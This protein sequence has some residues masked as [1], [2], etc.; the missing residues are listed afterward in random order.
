MFT[1]SC[2]QMNNERFDSQIKQF[3]KVSLHFRINNI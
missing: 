1:N 2:N 3:E